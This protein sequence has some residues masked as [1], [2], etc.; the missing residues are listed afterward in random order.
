[1]REMVEKET[2]ELHKPIVLRGSE[3]PAAFCLEKKKYPGESRLWLATP[4]KRV[5]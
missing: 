5:V 1:M 2:F 3:G 4:K